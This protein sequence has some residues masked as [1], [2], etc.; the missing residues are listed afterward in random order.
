LGDVIAIDSAFQDSG[1]TPSGQRAALHEYSLTA[2]AD[3][4][5]LKLL[6]LEATPR[7]LPFAECPSA[8]ANLTRLIGTPLPGLREKVLS[9][10][11]GTAGCTHLNDMLRALADVPALAKYLT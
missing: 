8:A 7:V 9:E 10:L 5:S 4:V 1:T 6:S 3:P 2:T 11:R